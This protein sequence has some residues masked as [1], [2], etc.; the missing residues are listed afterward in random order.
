MRRLLVTMAT[1]GAAVILAA[2]GSSGSN[3][4]SNGSSTAAAG[5]SAVTVAAKQV[6]G[7]GKVLVDSSGKTLYSPDEEANGMI[8]CTDTCTSF[9]VPLAANGTPTAGDGVAQL[10]VVDRPDG[11]KQVTAGGKPL[12]TFTQDSAGEVN[13]NGFSD[14][15]GNQHFTWHAVLADGSV[16]GAP[17]G[18]APATTGGYGY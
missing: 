15:F 14:D 10:G 3:G 11:A 13:G 7:V 2:C 1:A 8:L 12:Y 16:A 5:G 17:A 4:S 6:D 18:T 9:W